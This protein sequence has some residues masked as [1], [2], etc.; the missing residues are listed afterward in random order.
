MHTFIYENEDGQIVGTYILK[1]NQIDL[2]S[3]IANASFMV[4]PKFQGQ[5]IGKKLCEHCLKMAKELG[6]KAI[7]FNLVVS[8]NKAAISV[9]KRFG[10]EIIGTIPEAFNNLKLGKLVDA[11]IM[12]KKI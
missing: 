12:Y 3:H 4:H 1:P 7:Q 6:F 5:G 2:G 9:W 11:F 10:F 8:T